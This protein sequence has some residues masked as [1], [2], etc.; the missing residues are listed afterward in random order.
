MLSVFTKTTYFSDQL[1]TFTF[2]KQL[3]L[4][5]DFPRPRAWTRNSKL[6]GA[7]RLSDKV[8]LFLFLRPQATS[9]Q[10]LQG[11]LGV[12]R[13]GDWESSAGVL[14]PSPA[15][16]TALLGRRVAPGDTDA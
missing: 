15:A 3:K 13:V 12:A 11:D 10:G 5:S 7:Q 1:S 14:P 16:A 9:S 8:S 2:S 4:K 6:R